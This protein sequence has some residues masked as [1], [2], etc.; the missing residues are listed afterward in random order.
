[1]TRR[2]FLLLITIIAATCLL[3]YSRALPGGVKVELKNAQGESVGTATLSRQGKGVRIKLELKNLPP[4]EHAIHIHQTARCEG[5]AF[6]SAGPHFNPDAKKHGLKNPEGPHA[7]DMNNFIVKANGTATVTLTDRSVNL[8]TDSYSL[9][10]NG[11]TS[12]VIHAK[13]D[14][15]KTDPSG[16]SG[17]RI[18]CGVIT[19]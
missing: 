8:G 18:A 13:A 5:P 11:G 6:A 15:M 14:D 1:M 2:V 17:D 16:N 3:G 10:T 19:R 7:G 12:L 4:G 9:L